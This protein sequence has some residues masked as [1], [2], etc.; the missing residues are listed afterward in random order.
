M[1]HSNPAKL[2]KAQFDNTQHKQI[3]MEWK[4]NQWNKQNK[5]PLLSF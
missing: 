4:T 2:G 3:M 5:Y 1:T